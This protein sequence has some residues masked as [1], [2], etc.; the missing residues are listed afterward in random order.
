LAIWVLLRREGMFEALLPTDAPF[1]LDR[2][3]TAGAAVAA[4][5]AVAV[6]GFAL[7]RLPTTPDD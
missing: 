6:G 3:V 7:F 1:W 4:L 2:A 5:F